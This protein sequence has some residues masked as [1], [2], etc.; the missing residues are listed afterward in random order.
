M[1]L[2]ILYDGE[3]IFCSNYVTLLRLRESEGAIRLIDARSGD[4]EV[5]AAKAR[6]IDFDE[7]MVVIQGG[8][9]YRGGDAVYL[10]SLLSAD[11]SHLYPR[12]VHWLVKTPER[13]RVFYPWLR[14]GRNLALALRGKRKIGALDDTPS[15]K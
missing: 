12:L 1:S 2:T 14:A 11:R 10:L 7:S 9:D 3:C 5:A 6:G 8:K 15:R 13:A 4:P